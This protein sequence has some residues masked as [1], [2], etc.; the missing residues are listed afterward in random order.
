MLIFFLVCAPNIDD[1]FRKLRHGH[2]HGFVSFF[3]GIESRGIVFHNTQDWVD[4]VF[5][6]EVLHIG[7][8]VVEIVVPHRIFPSNV[9]TLH[10]LQRTQ[11]QRV[12]KRG[13]TNLWHVGIHLWL[14]AVTFARVDFGRFLHTQQFAQVSRALLPKKKNKLVSANQE[15]HV[16]SKPISGDV[17][18]ALLQVKDSHNGNQDDGHRSKHLCHHQLGRTHP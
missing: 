12:L 6:R 10:V 7:N 8:E 1:F 14:I 3:N 13:V 9:G 4:R 11:Q 16:S 18:H 2:A 5:V 15:T 17:A